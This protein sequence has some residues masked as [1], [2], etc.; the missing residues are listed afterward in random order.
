MKRDSPGAGLLPCAHGVGLAMPRSGWWRLA[1]DKGPFHIH[2]LLPIKAEVVLETLLAP[3]SCAYVISLLLSG[4]IICLCSG[5][6]ALLSIE[7]KSLSCRKQRLC[8]LPTGSL[9][10]WGVIDASQGSA[11]SPSHVQLRGPYADC[12]LCFPSSTKA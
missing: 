8:E 7:I 11:L 12:G 6:V 9:E 5:G 2:S 4:V 3:K 10:L 1:P